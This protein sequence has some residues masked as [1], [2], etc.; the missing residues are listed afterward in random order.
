MYNNLHVRF[1]KL[2]LEIIDS[3]STKAFRKMKKLDLP[4]AAAASCFRPS[5]QIYVISQQ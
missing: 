3:S 1:I 4:I 5:Q 2:N